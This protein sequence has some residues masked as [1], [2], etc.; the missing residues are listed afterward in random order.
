MSSQESIV[1]P[2]CNER[3][4]SGYV[5][6]P[7]CGYSFINIIKELERVHVGI[8]ESLS[9][10]KRTL[11]DPR[12]SEMVFKEISANPDIKGVFLILYLISVSYAMR[13]PAI[14]MR[15]DNLELFADYHVLYWFIAPWI[16]GIGFLLL[17]LFGWFAMG[18]LTWFM[19]KMLGG[20]TGFKDTLS[21]FGYSL[22]PLIPAS[23]AIAVIIS[24][25]GPLVPTISEVTGEA[26]AFFDFFYLPFIAFS[27]YHCGNGLRYSHLLKKQE[28]FILSG[29]I[30][31]FYI[32]FFI[33]QI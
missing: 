1:C 2:N 14:L 24:F 12:E 6:C 22:T 20:K 21:V 8:K 5:L 7:Y 15:T 30:A 16:V 18:A 9:R 13:L 29:A 10:F 19:A 23:A 33:I 11:Y 26:F 25:F 27:A 28:A 3:S 32:L 17:A 4:P 31:V